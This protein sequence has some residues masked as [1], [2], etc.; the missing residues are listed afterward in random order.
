MNVDGVVSTNLQLA[1]ARELLDEQHAEQAAQLLMGHLRQHGKDPRALALLGRAA[2]QIGAL[3]QA[4][5]FVRQG[6]AGGVNDFDTRRLLSSILGQQDRP[7]EAIPMVEALFAESRDPSLGVT[8]AGH[9]D[10]I[11]R[12]EESRA[13]YTTLAE[14]NPGLPPAWIS[15]GHCLRAAGEVDEA[16]AAYRRAIAIDEEFGEAWWGLASIKRRVFD[17]RDIATMQ[18]SLRVA[19]DERNVAPLHFALARA[20]HDQGDYEQAFRHYEEGNRIRAESINYDKTELSEEI[21]E[22]VALFDSAAIAAF[23]SEPLGPDRPTFIVSLPR[24][25]STLLEQILGSHPQVEPVGELS[26]IPS[27]LRSFMELATRRGKITVPQAI[28]WMSDEQ[29]LA[30]G[31]DY[32]ERAA[33]H[34][35]TDHPVFLDKLPHNWSNI[36]LIKR[37]LP[38][39]RFIDIRRPAMDCCFS[40]FT[41]SFTRFHASS[42]T[43]TDMAQSYCDNVQLMD[44]LDRVAP[45]L[46]HHVDYTQLV[47]H[48]R[49][50]ISGVLDYLGLAW[51]DAVL[52]FHKLDRVV[53]TPSSEQVRRPLNR[54]GMEVWRPYS[55]WL[56]PLR[57]ALGPLASA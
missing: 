4:E 2:M 56:G 54:D 40:N 10:K 3:R 37:I 39:A 44:H 11:G 24:S 51:D 12:S 41:Q 43:L 38:Q 28:R 27:I 36:L 57:E 7:I 14:E 32:L 50:Q 53:R 17:E 52:E 9:F 46:V 25:G 18:A 23:P 33:V 19:I 34:R 42:F 29:A 5:A 26:Y 49:E 21:D 55:Q 15:L 8:L 16:I 31:T 20:H 13:L 1:R 45:G 35:K 22:T 47:E 48:P 6:I 30:M